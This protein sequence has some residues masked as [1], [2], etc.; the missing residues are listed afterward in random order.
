[1][2]KL[3]DPRISLL[4]Q[5]VQLLAQR[6]HFLDAVQSQQVPPFPGAT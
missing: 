1:L 6:P 2:A 3:R 4:T 5:D